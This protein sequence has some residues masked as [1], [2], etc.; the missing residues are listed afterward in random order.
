MSNPHLLIT[1]GTGFIGQKLCP[2]LMKEGYQLTVLTRN[3]EQAKKRL[4]DTINTITWTSEIADLPPIDGVINLAGEGILDKRWSDTRKQELLNSRVALTEALVK[5]IVDS[6]H[7]PKTFINGSAVGFYGDCGDDV[8]S[9]KSA[10]GKDFAAMLC[11]QW[12]IAANRIKAIG[13]RLAIVRI[14][15]VLDK[16]GG[17]LERMAMP[18]KFGLGGKLGTGRQWFPWIHRDDLCK[19][20]LFLLNDNRCSGAYNATAPE[21]VTNSELTAALGKAM[22]RPTLLPAP[23]FALKLALGEASILLLGGQNA[24]PKKALQDGFKFQY[25]TI[26]HCLKDCVA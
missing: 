26:D 2:F 8:C 11:K 17:A 14:G 5:A 6:G 21:P 3:P 25:T 12:E 1:G 22:G 19:M 18:F 20:I 9:E 4:G 10:P 24:P 16:K 15:I 13:C 23:G 7:K